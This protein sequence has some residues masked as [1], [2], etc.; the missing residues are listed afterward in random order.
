MAERNRLG[1]PWQYVERSAKDRR[2]RPVRGIRF[3]LARRLRTGPRRAEH[4]VVV[5]C[6]AQVSSR[7]D[8]QDDG[9][10]R[11]CHGLGHHELVLTANPDGRQAATCAGN[12]A[13]VWC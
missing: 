13:P 1:G 10:I 2:G 8:D 12:K 3:W 5:V 7:Q 11:S 6:N 4:V 9:E